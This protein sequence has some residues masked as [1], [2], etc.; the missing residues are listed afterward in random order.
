M[1]RQQWAKVA[2]FDA[3]GRRLWE[4]QLS[5]D[6]ASGRIPVV[7]VRQGIVHA[8]W[9]E[10]RGE[11]V[12]MLRVASLDAG[13]NWLQ[14]ARDA[15]VAGRNT[16]NLNA[17]VGADGA[18]HVVFDSEQGSRAKELHWVQVRSERIE[19]RRL[20]EDDGHESAYPDL[21]FEGSRF[22]LTWFD[23]RD[24]NQ[25]VYLRCAD[26]DAMGSL[27]ADL[28]S[29][30]ATRRVT[31]TATE[32]IGAYVVWREG[33]VELAWTEGEGAQR[34]LWRQSFDRDCRPLEPARSIAGRGAEAGIPSLA[35]SPTGFMLA[36]NGLRG[37]PAAPAHGHSRRPAS[38]V[39]LK[40]WLKSTLSPN[41]A[42]R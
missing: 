26:L 24:G 40:V 23:S 33:R 16:W 37:D 9:L 13:G 34:A 17:A 4:R 42:A 32:S 38:V 12:P 29:E 22:A 8:A 30:D 14:P 7:R 11:A 36:W 28:K 3:S 6:G 18:F 15:A 2:R 20:S 10:Q 35:A 1:P 5:A 31:H 39:L 19:D 21:A 27:P 25:E 41:A